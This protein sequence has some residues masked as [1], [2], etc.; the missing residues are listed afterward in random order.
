MPKLNRKWTQA[1]LT[2]VLVALGAAG[3]AAMTMSKPPLAQKKPQPL[4]PRVRTVAVELAD[5]PVLVGG[6]GTAQPRR[7][8]SLSSEVKGRVVSVSPNLVDGAMVKRG[9]VL[10]RVER[11]D[12]ELNLT[13]KRAEV[14]GAANKLKQVREDAE[15]SLEEWRR[16]QGK[17]DAPPPLVA[18]EPQL[19]E[20]RARL[21][22][23]RAQ[24]AQAE[25]ELART[26]IAAPYD[27]RISG[28]Y[29]D[30]GQYLRVGDKVADIYGTAAAEVVVHLEDAALAWLKVPG[31]TT[32]QGPGSP[33]KV[34]VD[35][36]GKSVSWQG[37]ITRA[38][39]ELD[40]RTRMVAVIVQVDQ[41]FA[42]QPPLTPGMFVKVALNG[43]VL[44]AAALL[45]RAALRPGGQMWVVGQDGALKVTPV[46]VARLA[47]DEVLVSGG[48]EQ[49]A[50]VVVS[51]LEVVTDGMKVRPAAAGQNQESGS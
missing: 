14:A 46:E 16:F 43:R 10:L 17:K 38:Q 1:L 8:S 15:A 23:A 20:A 30:L 5:R 4:A 22:A 13:L 29:V 3:L 44:E 34:S 42:T 35:F 21:E 48:L 7:K 12:Y 47:G 11:R 31:L 50:Q 40:P 32:D 36:G 6:E 26:E 18:R 19:E 28:K 39:G 25:L 45:P 2:L 27:G 49:G 41:P 9:E 33:A 24:L 51:N 37:S